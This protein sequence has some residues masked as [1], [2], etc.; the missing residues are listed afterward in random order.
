MQD[1]RKLQLTMPKISSKMSLKGI[2]AQMDR[3]L[4]REFKGIARKEKEA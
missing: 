1:S 4:S 2:R 3:L